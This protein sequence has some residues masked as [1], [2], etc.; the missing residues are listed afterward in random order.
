[1]NIKQLYT[2][3]LSE[4]T[5]YISSKGEAAIIDRSGGEVDIGIDLVTLLSLKIPT[6]DRNNIPNDLKSIKAEKPG[7]RSL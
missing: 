5:Y 3:C 1:M 6:F 7:S 2:H 4:A